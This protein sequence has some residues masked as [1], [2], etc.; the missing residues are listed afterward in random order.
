MAPE[1]DREALLSHFDDRTLP[2]GCIEPTDLA[3]W[4]R[5]LDSLRE[6]GWHI[7]NAPAAD[8]DLGDLFQPD[9]ERPT[10]KVFVG[11]HRVQIN[12]FLLASTSIDF[13]FAT[14]E[15][16]DQH[17]VDSLGEFVRLCSR[18]A[19][20]PCSLSPEGSGT[21]VVARYDPLQDRFRVSGGRGSGAA[22]W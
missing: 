1:L 10:I 15:M 11:H 3:V 4:R 5:V 9:A 13:D 8:T 20:A 19:Q 21:P 16:V 22:D 6:S 12:V 14:A 17:A 7:E 2:D 18:A